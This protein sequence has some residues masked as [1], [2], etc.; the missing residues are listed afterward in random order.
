[1]KPCP[2]GA[3]ALVT[4]FCS[5][6]HHAIGSHLFPAGVC[7]ECMATETEHLA[8]AIVFVVQRV[9]RIENHVAIR[10]SDA[11]WLQR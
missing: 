4:E 5:T 10:N 3:G 2:L 8:N 6:C 9:E 1:M 7:T 11:E